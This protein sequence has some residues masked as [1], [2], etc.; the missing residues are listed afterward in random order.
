LA[1][2]HG[3]HFV[4]S[5]NRWR[6]SKD[7]TISLAWT[8]SDL[9]GTFAAAL[10]Q[11][12]A[13]FAENYSAGYVANLNADFKHF[14]ASVKRRDGTLEALT[15]AQ[16]VNYRALLGENH[17]GRLYKASRVIRLWHEQH[18]IDV[19]DDVVEL[20][21]DWK[22][23]GQVKGV[24]VRTRCPYKGPLTDMEFEAT[25]TALYTAL[26]TGVIEL[27]TFVLTML[28]YAT[29]RR[30]CQLRDLKI[31]DFIS[32]RAKDGLPA[33]ILRIPRAKQSDRG[34]DP[35]RTEFKNAALEPELGEAL[36]A[37][38]GTVKAKASS[39]LPRITGEMIQEMP[40]FPSWKEIA[41]AGPA[42]ERSLLGAFRSDFFHR[43]QAS[44]SFA[45]S[46]CIDKL[47]IHSERLD[48]PIHVFPYR[49]RRT[50]ATRAARE[51]YGD[52]VIAE[53]LDQTDTQNVKVYTE[54]VAENVD[55]ISAA[56]AKQLAPV[57]QAFAGVLVDVEAQARR[58]NDVTSRVKVC[59]GTTA[60]TCG[61]FG[62]CGALAP[63]A[64]YTC[65]HFQPW[66]DGPHEQVLQDLVRENERIQQ[67]TGDKTIASVN[68]RAIVA[69]AEVVRLCKLRKAA[70][71]R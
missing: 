54:N 58:G 34:D 60:G 42:T 40:V 10:R 35:W 2:H 48:R 65:T 61:K 4:P 28:F 39:L 49:L 15:A 59:G 43:T 11:A 23:K 38:V 53:L 8:E 21:N 32:A 70:V 51:G 69:V 17:L 27:S 47:E 44:I 24:A 45:V 41:T 30:P 13:Y 16:L 26:E 55:A 68:N 6:L 14:V 12:L 62:F 19:P 67:L 9:C 29:G 7:V 71:R 3:Y 46:H 56:V 1:R 5:E 25:L 52:L 57:A 33:Y 31:K 20:L 37:H 18:I 63:V 50:L 22:L 66:L 64:C 36:V